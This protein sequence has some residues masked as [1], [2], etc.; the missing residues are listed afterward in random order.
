MACGLPGKNGKKWDWAH[1]L[2]HVLKVEKMN[3]R[4]QKGFQILLILL[5]TKDEE[6][7]F[8]NQIPIDVCIIRGTE[9]DEM[10][11]SDK[12]TERKQMKA[13]KY[14]R[15]LMAAKAIRGKSN[16]TGKN[17]WFRQEA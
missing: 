14:F 1:L 8:Y 7:M 15:L 12:Q 9:C 16:C 3:E 4:N 10:G 11:K 13:R 5:N 6:Y 2:I 17:V